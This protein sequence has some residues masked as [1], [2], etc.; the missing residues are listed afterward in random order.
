MP[1]PK[2]LLVDDNPGGLVA[3]A[4]ILTQNNFE[5]TTAVTV[6]SAL[7][8]IA[9]T[10]FD[11]LLCDLNLPDTGDG[12]TV[13]SAMR[14]TDPRAVTIVFS[15]FPD[16]NRTLSAIVLQADEVLLRPLD[17]PALIDLI[18]DRLLNRRSRFRTKLSTVADILERQTHSTIEDWAERAANSLDLQSVRISKQERIEH[19]PMIFAI[20]V[21]R[22]RKPHKLEEAA[23]FSQPAHDHG[24][25]RWKQGYTIEMMVEESRML[26]VSIF[27]TLQNNL[28]V[29]DFGLVLV[30]VMAIADEVDSQLRQQVISYSAAEREGKCM[31]ADF[32]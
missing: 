1:K 13:V 21:D 25:L 15:A 32:E 30:D 2:I 29:I 7:H 4:E 3:L 26:Q 27:Q 19:L 9:T 5:V 24:C 8:S 11:V 6:K 10:K 23:S 31:T 12:F 22:L 28:S 18:E 16:V 17:V 20:V 14:H